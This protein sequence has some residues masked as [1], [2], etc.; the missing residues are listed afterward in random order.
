V[1]KELLVIVLGGLFTIVLYPTVAIILQQKL[2][3]VNEDKFD[4]GREMKQIEKTS[5]EIN[6]PIFKVF[7]EKSTITLQ[8]V[9]GM[10]D[11]SSNGTQV[12]DVTNRTNGDST[13]TVPRNNDTP[14][15]SDNKLIENEQKLSRFD[16]VKLGDGGFLIP[17]ASSEP[18]NIPSHPT[19]QG[20][21]KSR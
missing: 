19:T 6:K 18:G 16:N 12:N 2:M 4:H 9:S 20:K 15:K 14:T 5:S 7:D 1:R 17:P 8:D 11:N 21:E 3:T 13:L 10:K